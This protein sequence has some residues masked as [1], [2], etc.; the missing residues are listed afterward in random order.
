MKIVINQILI[1][2]ILVVLLVVVRVV[3]QIREQIR[4]RVIRRLWGLGMVQLSAIKRFFVLM[5]R[6]A[7]LVM[8]VV[9]LKVL[10][11]A[12]EIQRRE[13]S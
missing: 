9:R 3:I 5:K 4:F 8:M 6:I 11:V 7:M 10:L 2:L 1:L 13:L 12:Q